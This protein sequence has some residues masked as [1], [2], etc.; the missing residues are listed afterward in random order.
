MIITPFNV[1]PFSGCLN[2]VHLDLAADE[3]DRRV[4]VSPDY[5]TPHH[6]FRKHATEGPILIGCWFRV[7]GSESGS[8]FS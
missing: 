1:R 4:A 2:K 3:S 5:I 8:C 6:P 7:T